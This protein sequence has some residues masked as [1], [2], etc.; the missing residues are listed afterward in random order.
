MPNWGE[1]LARQEDEETPP[2]EVAG[3]R[4]L[5][6]I[7]GHGQGEVYRALDAEG[8]AVA[9]KRWRLPSPRAERELQALAALRAPGIVAVLGSAEDERTGLPCLIM[10]LVEGAPLS[11]EGRLAPR[12][13]ARRARDVARALRHV[14]AAGLVH[15]DV[16]PSNV[17]VRPDGEVVLVDFGVVKVDD[18]EGL[19]AQGATLGTAP[20]SPPEQLGTIEAPVDARS[21]VY[22]LGATLY[23][24]LSGAHPF[25]SEGRYEREHRDPWERP[26]SGAEVEGVPAEL[27]AIVS[28][29]LAFAPA[30]RY[31]SASE[32][33]QALGAFL[34]REAAPAAKGLGALPLTG[35]LALLLLLGVAAGSRLGASAAPEPSPPLGP[36]LASPPPP[37]PSSASPSP[38]PADASLADG[39]RE[40]VLQP[41][42]LAGKDT[43]VSGVGLYRNDNFG[44]EPILRVGY[45]PQRTR[46]VG[47]LR[48]FLGFDLIR[49]P[50]EAEVESAS[51]ELYALN[52][53]Y[54][55]TPPPP[56]ELSLV[57]PSP[58]G[59]TPWIEGTG[60]L[61]RGL[62]GLAW[63][64]VF[65]G[66][67]PEASSASPAFSQPECGPPLARA[68]SALGQWTR[69][70]A[71]AAVRAWRGQAKNLGLR[72]APPA[73]SGGEAGHWVFYSSDALE[74]E[75]R[76]RLRIR[77]RGPAA[78]P[79][80]EGSRDAARA[81]ARS[82]LA[83]GRAGADALATLSAAAGTAPFWGQPFW[84]RARW[85]AAQGRIAGARVDALRALQVEEP[86]APLPLLRLL[87]QAHL[88]Q[89]GLRPRLQ[90]A[91][92][93]ATLGLDPAEREAEQAFA[94]CL[95]RQADL[96]VALAQP[97]W[98]DFLQR[99]AAWSLAAWRR[100]AA[101][102][103]PLVPLAHALLLRLRDEEHAAALAALPPLPEPLQPLLAG[104]ETPA[105]ALALARL[106][107][108]AG[109]PAA[110]QTRLR[111]A[112]GRWPQ[113]RALL[114]LRAALD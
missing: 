19:T 26:P 2:P 100:V 99:E 36:A 11:S 112:L 6:R 35:G 61:D 109:G 105:A 4:V 18:A 30:A 107:L 8:R 93:L 47:E 113:D 49:L 15:R 1:I 10:E 108:L 71:S 86:V 28:R 97:R 106:A 95:A 72:L 5:E 64:G 63:S 38:P 78:Y 14:H 40:L 12:V 55:P 39:L 89:P 80:P 34:E 45:R 37:S 84:E 50:R 66:P 48:A 85:G 42:P 57:L 110:A 44:V 81:R 20:Y 62:D 103:T 114:Q 104:P 56:L 98:R 52:L 22:A 70:D 91:L 59:R 90:G 96:R 87:A 21:D 27:R 77:Y 24:S 111:A 79:P 68:T 83:A 76:P 101:P 7:A 92:L 43:Y 32:L 54:G 16:K 94:E 31:A 82:L 67:S 73:G 53:V 75:L 41:G 51:L 88:A 33:E 69:W 46:Q 74:A 3:Y 17:L 102:K 25:E 23:E 60:G 9:L 58:A 29:C 13:A 65:Q